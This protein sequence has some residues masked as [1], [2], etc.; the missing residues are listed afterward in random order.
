[1]VLAAAVAA[2]QGGLAVSVVL[3]EEAAVGTPAE[4]AVLAAE[5][6]VAMAAMS[7]DMVE[8]VVVAVAAGPYQLEEAAALEAEAVAA[9]Q[10][11]LAETAWYF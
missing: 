7:A 2:A 1:M 11:E 9:I 6:G 3:E 10:A 8:L 4:L 5:A